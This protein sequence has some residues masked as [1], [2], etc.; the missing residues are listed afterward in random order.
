MQE[1]LSFNNICPN[2]LLPVHKA[3]FLGEGS[4]GQC[5]IRNYARLNIPVV[6][7][8][9]SRSSVGDIIKEAQ[10]MQLLSHPNIPTILGVQCEK[11]PFSIVMQFIGDDHSSCTVHDLL[12]RDDNLHKRDWVKISLNI[13]NALAH[14]H[15]KGYL[16]CDLKSNN[17]LVSN[18]AGYL[19]DFGKACRLALPS[20]KKYEKIYP[21]IAPEVLGGSPC[22]KQSDVYSLGTVFYKIGKRKQITTLSDIAK[23]CLDKNPS[24]RM[25]LT[26]IMT[27]LTTQNEIPLM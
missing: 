18:G 20:A 19:I 1:K 26:G 12:G 6:E 11:P 15:K 7:K 4:F 25:T 14:V 13:A 27:T 10:I 2:E 23:K 22:S 5:F 16:H 3:G 21:H 24:Q 17:V 8:Q 9:M